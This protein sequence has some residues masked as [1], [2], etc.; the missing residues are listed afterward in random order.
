MRILHLLVLNKK[1]LQVKERQRKITLRK[2]L[3]YKTKN[4]IHVSLLGLLAKIK[5]KIK[6]M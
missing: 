1:T 5:C 2:T 3:L 4:K 6:P